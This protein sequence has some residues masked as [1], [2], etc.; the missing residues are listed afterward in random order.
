[1]LSTYFS[2]LC[3]TELKLWPSS[4]IFMET[5]YSRQLSLI[6]KLNKG[7][8]FT[9]THTHPNLITEPLYMYLNNQNKYFETLIIL[10]IS[11]QTLLI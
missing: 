8:K 11:L 10:L 5:S 3:A 4:D 9:H 7:E 1:M 2:S 6:I